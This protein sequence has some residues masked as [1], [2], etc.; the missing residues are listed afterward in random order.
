MI[1]TALA[2]IVLLLI[3]R[4]SVGKDIELFAIVGLAA[5]TAAIYGIRIT[6]DFEGRAERS[7]QA[8]AT[9]VDLRDALQSDTTNLFELRARAQKVYEVILGDIAQ[10][11]YATQSRPL[12]VTT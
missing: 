1:G 11:R 12:A 7:E 6:G 10:W 9:L 5:L 2:A 3:P 4:L 8:A